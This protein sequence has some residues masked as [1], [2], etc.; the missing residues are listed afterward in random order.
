MRITPPSTPS[1]ASLRATR[2]SVHVPVG[3]ARPP[4]E[5][6]CRRGV[7]VHPVLD[8]L[9]ETLSGER[10][11][12]F[13]VLIVALLDLLGDALTR[14]LRLGNYRYPWAVTSRTVK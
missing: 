13:V 14:L 5:P 9:E 3:R 2:K 7:A 8:A 1:L 10:S 12:V 6:N 4:V 11:L